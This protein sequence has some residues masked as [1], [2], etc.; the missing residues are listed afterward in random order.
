MSRRIEKINQAI[1]ESVS[2]TILFSL[3]DPRVQNVTVTRVETAPDTR[4]AKVYVSVMGDEAEQRLCLHGLNSARGFL[5][6][7]V[8]DRIETRFTPVLEFVLDQGIKKSI[9]ASRLIREAQADGIPL[10]GD[11]LPGNVPFGARVRGTDEQ[12]PAVPPGDGTNSEGPA[13]DARRAPLATDADPDDADERGATKAAGPHDG[14]DTDR[15]T[16]D[17]LG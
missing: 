10:P 15:G 4:T 12:P 17:D 5:Q 6:R 2:S 8:A 1:L 11:P 13:D 7:K 16:T 9:E 14:S 3:R